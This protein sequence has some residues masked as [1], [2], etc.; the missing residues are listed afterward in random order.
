MLITRRNYAW[1]VRIFIPGES[2]PFWRQYSLLEYPTPEA[3]VRR[4]VMGLANKRAGT[5]FMEHHD[6]AI[7][8][9]WEVWG[10]LESTSIESGKT[11]ET[12]PPSP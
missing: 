4:C 9:R 10:F 12:V 3:A 6:S 8:V 2:K 1:L 11:T 5:V 7:S